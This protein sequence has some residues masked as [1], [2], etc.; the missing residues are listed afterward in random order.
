MIDFTLLESCPH[1]EAPW[2]DKAIPEHLQE[3]YGGARWFSR[4]IGLYGR[5]RDRTIAWQCPDCGARWDRDTGH[6]I[7][8]FN[9]S[10]E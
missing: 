10:K 1:C 3:S 9:K 8:G 2:R 7:E 6:R 5:D 4:V